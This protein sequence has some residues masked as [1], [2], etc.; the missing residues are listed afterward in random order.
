MSKIHPLAHV[1][2][3]AELGRDVTVGPF[4]HVAADVVIGDECELQNHVTLLG[5]AQF[6]RRNTFYPMCALGSAPQDLKYKGGPTLLR[7]GD[8]NTFR[9]YVSVHRGTEIGR[10]VTEIGNENL[11]MVGVHIA[12]DVEVHNHVILANYVQVAGHACIENCVNI[13]GSSAMH[14][15]VTVGRYAYVGGLTPM[16]SDVPPYMKVFGNSTAVRGVNT[17]G[18]SR[19]GIDETSIAAV[20][21]AFRLIFG[22]RREQTPGKTA[23]ALRE[24]E[25]DGRM[26]DEHV[27]YLTRFLKR[28]MNDGVFGRAREAARRDSD[29]DRERFYKTTQRNQPA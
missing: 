17:I 2:P 18:M 24:I 7:V 5:P 21:Q 6:G 25:A 10:G 1:D 22:K 15:F 4:C 11:L 12:H 26:S 9:E 27:L 20:K 3:K 14:H 8:D 16:R 29:C 28:Q 23:A 13:G 19:W